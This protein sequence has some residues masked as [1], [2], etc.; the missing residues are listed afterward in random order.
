MTS[1]QPW[2]IVNF[3]GKDYP[4]LL[5]EADSILEELRHSLAILHRSINSERGHGWDPTTTAPTVKEWDRLLADIRNRVGVS[6]RSWAWKI[7][8]NPADK[9]AAEPYARLERQ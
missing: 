1:E 3:E 7:T 5:A 6:C 4:A 8:G 2:W 9:V